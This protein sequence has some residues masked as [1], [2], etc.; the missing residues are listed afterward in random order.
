[1][2]TKKQR[3]E[4]ALSKREKFLKAYR[5]DGLR[6]QQRDHEQRLEKERKA[7]ADREALRRR[8]ET[9]QAAG[10]IAK[11]MKPVSAA[12]ENIN[13]EM[14]NDLNAMDDFVSAMEFGMAGDAA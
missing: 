3:R 10:K 8:S 6:A 13:A 14:I 5:E 1:M 9:V 2:T 7:A 11:A 4:T 12:V